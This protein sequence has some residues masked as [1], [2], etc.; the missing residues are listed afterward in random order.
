M[1]QLSLFRKGKRMDNL[2]KCMIQCKKDGFGCHYGA[3]RA[4]QGEVLVVKDAI[5]EGWKRCEFCGE[6]FK[7]SSKRPQKYCGAYCQQRSSLKRC[8]ERKKEGA[9]DGK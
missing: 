8:Q 1:G 7:P 9:E 3:W 2:S 4:L 6:A 5:P